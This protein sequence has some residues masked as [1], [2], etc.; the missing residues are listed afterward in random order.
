M[1]DITPKKITKDQEEYLNKIKQLLIYSSIPTEFIIERI[2]RMDNDDGIFFLR[3]NNPTDI[4]KI[5]RTFP[6]KVKVIYIDRALKWNYINY[7][8]Q[9][10]KFDYKI[11]NRGTIEEFKKNIDIFTNKKVPT[12]FFAD[13]PSFIVNKD[14]DNSNNTN[15]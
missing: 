10:F 6:K 1:K 15:I 4:I 14:E 8:P 7:L 11:E 3:I 9:D 2:K 5:R 13:K 12:K